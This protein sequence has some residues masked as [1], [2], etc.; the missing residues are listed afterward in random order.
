MLWSYVRGVKSSPMQ[1][2]TLTDLHFYFDA[3]AKDR[4]DIAGPA[5]RSCEVIALRE[6]LMNL[7]EPDFDAAIRTIQKLVEH[8][9]PKTQQERLADERT[10][11]AHARQLFERTDPVSSSS[12]AKEV[13]KI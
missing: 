4:L 3:Q 5:R 11:R 6:R 1:P 8:A 10:Q 7:P 12:T 9:K 13:S 2:I